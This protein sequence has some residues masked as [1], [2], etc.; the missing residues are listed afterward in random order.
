VNGN[1]NCGPR[2]ADC[3]SVRSRATPFQK[4]GSRFDLENASNEN[5]VQKART[6]GRMDLQCPPN[7]RRAVSAG[8]ARAGC[9]PARQQPPRSG[10]RSYT[11]RAVEEVAANV[12]QKMIGFERRLDAKGST[13]ASPASGPPPAPTA[14]ARLSRR[15]A[16]ATTASKLRIESG[17]RGSRYSGRFPDSALGRRD[18]P[19]CKAYEPPAPPARRALP[20]APHP[21]ADLDLVPECDV[22]IPHEGTW[23]SRFA[24]VAQ[25]RA[26]RSASIKESGP[27]ASGSCDAMGR[28]HGPIRSA[29][30]RVAGAASIGE[31][32]G[33]PRCK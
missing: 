14:T 24:A 20:E 5:G 7:R 28:E 19:P 2:N 27:W 6:R 31:R 26:R 23:L 11:A 18:R 10:A 17:E 33:E 1:N 21:E 9:P 12:R 3:A 22:L 16:R 25:P 15:G 30:C 13:M 8:H 29:S 4:I 32:R